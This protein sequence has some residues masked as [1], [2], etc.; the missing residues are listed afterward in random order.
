MVEKDLIKLGKRIRKLRLANKMTLA[1]LAAQCDFEKS[2]MA[3]IEQGNTN[4]TYKTLYK[5]SKALSISVS[6][7]VAVE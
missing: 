5:I 2:N 3:R 4:P 7:L 1:Q 6:E